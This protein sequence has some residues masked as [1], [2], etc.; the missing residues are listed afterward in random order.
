MSVIVVVLVVLVVVAGSV[1]DALTPTDALRRGPVIVEI[2]AHDGTIEVARRLEEGGVVRNRWLF[3]G[4]AAVR[5]G[6]RSLKAGEYEFP[7]GSSPL[8]VVRYVASG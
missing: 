6:V 5:G 2:P 1:L 7:Q 8:V 4:L 3:L